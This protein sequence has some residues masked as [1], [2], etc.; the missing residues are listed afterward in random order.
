MVT[1]ARSVDG[2]RIKTLDVTDSPEFVELLDYKVFKGEGDSWACTACGK[3]H[4]GK[5]AMAL[6]H[7]PTASCGACRLHGEPECR[8]PSCKREGT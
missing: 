1:R 7:C 4:T 3:T 8:V 6:K 5:E 2:F